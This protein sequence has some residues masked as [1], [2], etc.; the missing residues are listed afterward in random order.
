MPIIS[1]FYGITVRM[2]FNDHEPPHVHVLHEDKEAVVEINTGELL[3][4]SLK[5]Q[6]KR[7]IKEWLDIHRE[8]LLLSWETRNIVKIP[9][10]E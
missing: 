6:A 1:G 8:E 5:P 9:P 2:H 3:H 7:M 4:G 10:L